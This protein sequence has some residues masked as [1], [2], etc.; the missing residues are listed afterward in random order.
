MVKSRR[1]CKCSVFKPPYT[2]Y[3]TDVGVGDM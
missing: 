2:L 1:T 3:S